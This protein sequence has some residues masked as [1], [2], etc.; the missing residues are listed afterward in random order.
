MANCSMLACLN[1]CAYTGCS[2]SEAGRTRVW[3]KLVCVCVTHTV[4]LESHN[5]QH[6]CVSVCVSVSVFPPNTHKLKLSAQQQATT[7][8]VKL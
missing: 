6:A 7:Y 5:K 3:K 4:L 8:T 2:D 1:V